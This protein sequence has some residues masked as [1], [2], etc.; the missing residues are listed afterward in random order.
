MDAKL[1]LPEQAAGLDVA[2]IGNCAISALV[3]RHG[4]IVWCCMPRFDGDPIFHALL[5]SRDGLPRDGTCAIEIEDFVRSEQEYVPGTAVLRTRLYDARGDALEISDFCP[6]FF[7]RDRPFRPAQIV[8]HISNYVTLTPGDVIYTGAPGATP[9]SRYRIH[10][11][12]NDC[13]LIRRG[14]HLKIAPLQRAHLHHLVQV[15]VQQA[16][17]HELGIRTRDVELPRSIQVDAAGRGAR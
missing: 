2:L 8:S 7:V 4:T 9:A 17:F 12:P 13:D 6:R 14:D 1:P 15:H 10:P 3:N 11:S 16:G 5:D